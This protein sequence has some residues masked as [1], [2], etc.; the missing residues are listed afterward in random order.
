VTTLITE[1]A[2]LERG[3]TVGLVVLGGGAAYAGLLVSRWVTSGLG[4][5]SFTLA[6]VLAF[7]AIVLGG[8]IVF[9][10]FFMSV[11]AETR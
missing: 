7:T 9:S 3:T 1:H 8:L 4:S 10:S 5:V 2:S 6:S 11:L